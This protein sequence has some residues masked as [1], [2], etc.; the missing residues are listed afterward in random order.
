MFI[1]TNLIY[2]T[3]RRTFILDIADLFIKHSEGMSSYIFSTERGHNLAKE[4]N[5]SSKSSSS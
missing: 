4:L 2:S 3:T 1:K 5:L